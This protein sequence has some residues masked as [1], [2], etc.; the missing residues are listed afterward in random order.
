MSPAG[1]PAP[2]VED[3]GDDLAGSLAD[4]PL[5]ITGRFKPEIAADTPKSCPL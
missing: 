5:S 2:V 3:D 4:T 1:T